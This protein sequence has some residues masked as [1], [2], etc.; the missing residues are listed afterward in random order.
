MTLDERFARLRAELT[1][2]GEPPPVRRSA[3]RGRAVAALAAVVV[4]VAAVGA[5]VWLEDRDGTDVDRTPY[6]SAA[7]LVVDRSRPGGP[8]VPPPVGRPELAAYLDEVD[9]VVQDV[10]VEQGMVAALQ[11]T[12]ATAGNPVQALWVLP[13]G[14][15]LAVDVFALERPLALESIGPPGQVT[16]QDLDDGSVLLT[17]VP[18][19]ES[20][21][22][23]RV[24]ADGLVVNARLDLRPPRPLDTAELE[25]LVAALPSR[26]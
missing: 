23:L 9:P 10:A 6:A 25:A 15:T 20:T 8:T 1:P 16:R 19:D 14:S 2:S 4:V 12:V 26:S 11:P 3:R 17:Y 22:V 21:Q 24:F 7:H 13:R 18:H 5:A